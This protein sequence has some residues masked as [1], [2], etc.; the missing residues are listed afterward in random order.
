MSNRANVL[1][2]PL[3]EAVKLQTASEAGLHLIP[4][5]AAISVGSVL[6][7]IWMRQ[8]GKCEVLHNTLSIPLTQHFVCDA[9]RYYRFTLFSG[10]LVVLSSALLITFDLRTPSW[11]MYAAIAPG[12]ASEAA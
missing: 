7:G 1:R 6:A 2:A 4:N 8:T 3:Q 12:G 10:A 5:S 9:G 11:L